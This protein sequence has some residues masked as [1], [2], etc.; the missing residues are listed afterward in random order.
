MMTTSKASYDD[1]ELAFTTV[2]VDNE[3]WLD[4]VTGEVIYVTDDLRS[5]F[6]SDPDE[7]EEWERTEVAAARLLRALGHDEDD[8]LGE[9]EEG[10]TADRYV[11]IP[12]TPSSEAFQVMEDFVALLDEEN[13]G[14]VVTDLS[15]ALR[16]GKPFRRFKDALLDYPAV[17]E[18]WFKF[19]NDRLRERI[20]EW[21]ADEGITLLSSRSD[22]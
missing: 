4:R 20:T 7:L 12:D 14:Q 16:G 5:L 11:A 13:A 19:E 9:P 3:A 21:A 1:I 17:R 6:D 10:E 22:G 2:S 15:R 8:D 18:R